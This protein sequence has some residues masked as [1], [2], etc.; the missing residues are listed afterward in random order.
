MERIKSRLGLIAV[1]GGIAALVLAR[2]IWDIYDPWHGRGHG[3]GWECMTY[4]QGGATVCAK[5]VPPP[6]AKHPSSN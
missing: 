6:V 1:V 2:M 5:D 3:P 4:G